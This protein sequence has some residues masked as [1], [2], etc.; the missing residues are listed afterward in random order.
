MGEAEVAGGGVVEGGGEVVDGCAG[1]GEVGVEGGGEEVAV[2]EEDDVD[3]GSGGM[4]GGDGVAGAVIGV[5][6][7]EGPAAGGEGV[8]DLG[9]E[10]GVGSDGE[11]DLSH[12]VPPVVSTVEATTGTTPCRRRVGRWQCRCQFWHGRCQIWR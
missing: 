12:G 11:V 10:V 4:V 1:E 6:V 5:G 3:V 7:V 2:G 9:V 8:G